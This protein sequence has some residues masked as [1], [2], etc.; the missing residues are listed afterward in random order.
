MVTPSWHG[1]PILPVID[2]T[3]QYKLEIQH[4]IKPFIL[5]KSCPPGSS[6]TT[7]AQPELHFVVRAE[8]VVSEL[9]VVAGPDLIILRNIMGRD[10]DAHYVETFKL[11]VI[12]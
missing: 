3:N 5:L 4:H 12:P 6:R 1:D 9:N 7:E 10:I 11:C 2:M 8:T